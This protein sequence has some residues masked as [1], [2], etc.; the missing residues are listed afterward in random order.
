MA[1]ARGRSL[2]TPAGVYR[3]LPE[4]TGVYRSFA[5]NKKKYE[6]CETDYTFVKLAPILDV[7]G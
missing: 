1:H 3:S 5:Y 2:K 7:R 6:D 4:F